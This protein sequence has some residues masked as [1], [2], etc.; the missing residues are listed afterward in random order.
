MTGRRAF[1]FGCGCCA[2]S[3]L[4]QMPATPWS[5]PQRFARPLDDSDEGGLWG[6]MD[7]E[8]AKLKRS[9]FLVR[10]PAL[11]EYVSGI[12]CRLAGDH[13]PDMRVYLVRT[14]V[15]NA[16]MAPNGMMQVWSGLLLRLAG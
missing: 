11:N 7:R 8:E 6:L 9:A 2:L 5:A 3:A 13:C 4:A 15:F 16:S 10:D 14:P 1:V 12:A